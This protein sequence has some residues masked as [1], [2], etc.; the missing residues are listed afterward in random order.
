M[1]CKFDDTYVMYCCT[2]EDVK[3]NAENMVIDQVIGEHL[4]NKTNS[5]VTWLDV[6]SLKMFHLS[7]DM[8]QTFPN[9]I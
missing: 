6:H 2:A 8:F 7:K 1:T 3:I 9:L 4:D 5:D